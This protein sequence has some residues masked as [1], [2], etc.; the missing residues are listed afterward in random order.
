MGFEE[1]TIGKIKSPDVFYF[2]TVDGDHE[3]HK[4]QVREMKKIVNLN[5]GRDNY[6]LKYPKFVKRL[7]LSNVVN[8]A[9]E[10]GD[11]K[12]LAHVIAETLV[13]NTP[14]CKTYAVFD[15]IDDRT[16]HGDLV[17]QMKND[18]EKNTFLDKV[19]T[20]EPKPT[21]NFFS[22][23]R[24]FLNE[25]LVTAI[26]HDGF[27]TV[28]EEPEDLTKSD[29]TQCENQKSSVAD[30]DLRHL[31]E[32]EK[33][34]I[35]RSDADK[36]KI[37]EKPKKKASSFIQFNSG[38]CNVYK[39]T[40]SNDMAGAIIGHGGSRIRE[41]RS[42][43]KARI[44]IDEPVQGSDKRIVNISGSQ[45]QI[46]AAQFL[47]HQLIRELAGLPPIQDLPPRGHSS[48][49]ANFLKKDKKEQELAS[50]KSEIKHLCH[51]NALVDPRIL[52]SEIDIDGGEE[53][54]KKVQSENGNKETSEY[55][56]Q[57]TS[58]RKRFLTKIKCRKESQIEG[59]N[60]KQ[61]KIDPYDQILARLRERKV[62]R[63]QISAK[64][65]KKLVENK[66]ELTEHEARD[67]QEETSKNEVVQD[68]IN[69]PELVHSM[70][71]LAFVEKI[72]K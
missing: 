47:L 72:S 51:S 36:T 33:R 11:W 18:S 31:I 67:I 22:L 30:N 2:V 57:T 62:A 46:Q 20:K 16:Y 1:I 5:E 40:I 65:E 29:R 61:M 68:L 37:F 52:P 63:D 56:V 70:P 13:G 32:E 9:A 34:K 26:N 71:S 64:N 50:T 3:V 24:I 58:K 27:N 42:N 10:Y 43:S 49:L 54:K 44:T 59:T 66:E 35:T 28:D 25:G 41:I 17:I 55:E 60:G 8:S 14:E 69:H 7:K 23:K 6:R 12:I 4:K 21:G 38:N 45:K 48:P 39:V 15:H 53:L 19:L